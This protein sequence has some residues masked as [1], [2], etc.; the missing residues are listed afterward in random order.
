MKKIV[1]MLTM[2]LMMAF[3]AVCN[4]SN[5]KVLDSEEAMVNKFLSATKYSA[6]ESMLDADFK[7]EFTEETF[8]NFKEQLGKN[9]GKL[10]EKNLFMVEKG[11]KADALRYRSSFELAPEV[12]M[13]FIF[14]V[15]NEKPLL[16]N[17]ALALPPKEDKE[18]AENK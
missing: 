13:L 10:N 9:F 14:K 5:G 15:E 7:K 18:K 4:A 6:V 1:I 17:F 12:Q 16:A 3:T 8:N 11:N 2:V